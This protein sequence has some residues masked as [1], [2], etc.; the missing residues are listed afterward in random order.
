MVSGA[1]IG[2][3]VSAIS[4][5]TLSSS[6]G[7]QAHTAFLGGFVMVFGARFASGCTRYVTS[8][9][10]ASKTLIGLS[11]NYGETHIQ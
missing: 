9:L 3:L 10:Y 2:G 4:S 8:L 1:V 7:V 11:I 6:H 5:S